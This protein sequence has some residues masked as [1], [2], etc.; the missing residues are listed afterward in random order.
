MRC[1]V[2]LSLLLGAVGAA[3]G[4]HVSEAQAPGALDSVTLAAMRW[5]AVGPA[6]MGGRIT[7]V[8][9]IPS[10]S[11]TFYVAAAGG[12]IWKSTNAGTTF[13]PIFENQRCMSMGDLA[14]APSDTNTIYAGTGEQNSRNSISPGCGVF[15]ST[16]GGRTWNFLGLPETEHIGRIQVHPKD[17]NIVYMAVLGSA[18]RASNARGLYKSTDGGKTWTVVKFISERAGFIDVQL[19]PTNP[20]IL[21]AS[22]YERMRGPY[23]LQ[24][25]G[26]G[27]ALWKS[28]DAGATWTKVSGGGFPGA[29][30]G[31]IEIAIARSNPKI[32]YTQVEADTMPN[33]VKDAKKPAQKSNSGLYRSEDGGATW[34]RTNTDNTRPFYYSQVRVDPRNPDRVYWSSTPVKVSDDGGKTARDATQGIHVDHHAMWID[35]TD[36]EHIIVGNDGGVAQ[37]WDK[38]GSY[39]A[40]TTINIGQFYAISF[41]MATPYHICGG[42]Q[43]NGSWCGPSRRVRGQI[44][45]ESWVYVSG[46]DGFYTAQDP[47]D[48]DVVYSESQGGNIGRLNMSTGERQ[49]LVKPSW[50][51]RYMQFEDSIII[52]RGDTTAQPTAAQK[53]RLAALR[54]LQLKDS[55]EFDMRWN[56]NTP[57]FLSPHNPS[58]FYAGANRVVKSTKRGEDLMVISPDLSLRDTMKIRVSTKTTGGIT[59]DATGAET[60]GTIVSLNESPI[61]PGLLYAGTDDGN[62]WLTRNDGAMWERIPATRFTGLPAETYVS[63]IEASHH[64]SATFYITFDDHRRGN[65]TP[66][67]YATHDFGTT[68]TSLAAT[69]PSGAP[70]FVHVIREDPENPDLLFLGTDVGAYVSMNKGQSWQRFMTGLP[71]VPVHDLQIHPRDHELIAGTHGRAIYVVDIAPLQQMTPTV[72]TKKVHLFTPRTALAMGQSPDAAGSAGGGNG[73]KRF[74]ANSPPPGAEIAYRITEAQAGKRVQIVITDAAGDTM[75][76][77]NGPGQVGVHRVM[78]DMRGKRPPTKPLSPAEKRDSVK[79]M[80]RIGQVFDSLLASGMDSNMVRTARTAML[81]GRTAELIEQFG[82]FGGGG[83]GGGGAAQ[84]PGIPRF[85]DRP[86]E[87]ATPVAGRGGR[88]GGAPA[89]PQQQEGAAP[90]APATAAGGPP[91]GGMQAIFM[92]FRGMQDGPLG[93]AARGGG[94]PLVK[95]GEYLV[96]LLYGDE[97]QKQVL[98]V[99]RVGNITGVQGFGGEDEDDGREDDGHSR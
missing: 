67:V 46:G 36:P 14:I 11:K 2:R 68:F 78:W 96:T 26:P 63:R 16:D 81:S 74:V 35:P 37:T 60:F 29:T 47:T 70:D 95:T 13:R 38:G 98:R 87:G 1:V 24:S 53:R 94:A 91:A 7:D 55:T 18:W 99:E 93:R 10:P 48:A 15:K 32:M 82:G 25:G 12:G 39:D 20:D 89:A 61:R 84:V 34:T 66:Y 88:A 58:V 43:D 86:G 92:A 59:I 50:R 52:E 28:T 30:L 6:N 77:L 62:V 51:P 45:N 65:F 17:P 23:F 41:D 75:R 54:A 21:W 85:A 83:G 9:G 31:R 64:D 19:D 80:V 72:A 4:A 49:S 73:H 79:T 56:W 5:R 42:L 33:A 8:E 44:S 69:L 22:S 3:L 90:A 76:T 27:S 57:F 71:T 97:K 40:L